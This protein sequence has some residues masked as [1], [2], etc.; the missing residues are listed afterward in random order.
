MK[1]SL[2]RVGYETVAAIICLTSVL[3][4]SL[5]FGNVDTTITMTLVAAIAGLG[6]FAMGHVK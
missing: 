3:L 5:Y 2:E 1:F 4:S 6:G